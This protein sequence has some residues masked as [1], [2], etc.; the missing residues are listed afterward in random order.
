MHDM[1]QRVVLY[2][3][4]EVVF[5]HIEPMKQNKDLISIPKIF[6]TLEITF[7]FFFGYLC[8]LTMIYCY[9]ILYYIFIVINL[10]I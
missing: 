7:P 5:N 6:H 9:S 2:H 3:I 8:H 10:N 1:Q 4:S